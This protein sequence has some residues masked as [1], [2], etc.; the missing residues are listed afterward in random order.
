[1]SIL[2]YVRGTI[3]KC[4]QGTIVQADVITL[5]YRCAQLKGNGV[6]I[7]GAVKTKSMVFAVLAIWIT[8]SRQMVYPFSVYDLT[9]GLHTKSV[10]S[11]GD[12]DR[13]QS[14][15]EIG[16]DNFPR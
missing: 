10:I 6:L 7:D 11:S 16:I 9:D 5:L 14:S 2:L 3:S 1:M 8:I 12:D 15:I 13:L 4:F